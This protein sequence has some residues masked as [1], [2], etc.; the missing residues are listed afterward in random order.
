M[1][2]FLSLG[3]TA[4]TMALDVS[5]M[6]R[7]LTLTIWLV[8][9]GKNKSKRIYTRVHLLNFITLQMVFLLLVLLVI[10]G[11]VKEESLHT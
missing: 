11:I 6:P 7:A 9:F 5:I 2:F 4:A 8:L 1:S 3:N 10:K